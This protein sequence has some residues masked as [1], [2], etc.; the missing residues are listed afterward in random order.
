MQL[1]GPKAL[2]VD[3]RMTHCE[4]W[5]GSIAVLYITEGLAD[6]ITL[7]NN[8]E[9]YS[10]AYETALRLNGVNA[11]CR[12]S[13]IARN[14]SGGA[15]MD[16]VKPAVRVAKGV[17]EN[18]TVVGNDG[19]ASTCG[20]IYVAA[21]ADAV[22]RNCISFGNLATGSETT[23][24]VQLAD[25][26]SVSHCC[27]PDLEG[28]VNGNVS[29]DPMFKTVKGTGF[30]YGIRSISPCYGTALKLPWMAGAHDYLPQPRVNAA[31]DIGCGESQ[32]K[33]LML[34]VK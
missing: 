3:S 33:G 17:L 16:A 20:G 4:S 9:H 21:D 12:N 14:A 26:A 13:F 28:G 11:V 1:R 19:G 30:A 5:G 18:C 2:F 31:P 32:S 8:V 23:K 7:T 22:V 27:S 25:G 29:A 34:M 6:R 15:G 10:N 24:N